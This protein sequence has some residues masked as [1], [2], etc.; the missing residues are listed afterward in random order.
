MREIAWDEG[1]GARA[2]GMTMVMDMDMGVV[3]HTHMAGEHA[4]G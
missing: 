4:Q 1:N 3:M 2:T